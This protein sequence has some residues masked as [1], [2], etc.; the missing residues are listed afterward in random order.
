M[1]PLVWIVMVAV[2]LAGLALRR[3]QRRH[4]ASDWDRIPVPNGGFIEWRDRDD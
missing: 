1:H 4:A 3:W 2:V